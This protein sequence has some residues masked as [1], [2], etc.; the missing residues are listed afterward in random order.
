MGVTMVVM[1]DIIMKVADLTVEEL[2]TLIRNVLHEQ[3][4]DFIADPDKGAGAY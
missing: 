3:L 1:R 4:Q 2:Q